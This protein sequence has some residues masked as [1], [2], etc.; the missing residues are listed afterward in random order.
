MRILQCKISRS[1]SRNSRERVGRKGWIALRINHFLDAF[2]V[3]VCTSVTRV[4]HVIKY[5]C[6]YII[7]R[8]CRRPENPKYVT[9]A[10]D[11]AYFATRLIVG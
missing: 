1:I 7:T 5:P 3:S 9:S 10:L 4:F 6:A 11:P 2:F 8:M